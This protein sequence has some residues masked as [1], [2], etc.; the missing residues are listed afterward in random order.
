[1][2]KMIDITGQTFGKLTIS[3]YMG[4]DGKSSTWL[5]IC[6]CGRNIKVSR[7]KLRKG[8]KSCGCLTAR[9]KY[10][11]LFEKVIAQNKPNR[12]RFVYVASYQGILFKIGCTSNVSERMLSLSA[13]FP[14]PIELVCFVELN[15]ASIL[16]N[17]LHIKYGKHQY[18]IMKRNGNHFSR[19]FFRID[20]QLI[21]KD[22]EELGL[23]VIHD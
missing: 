11:N 9:P 13:E 15:G 20:L 7:H 8:K 3:C 4:S 6:K 22:L 19:E 17:A 1:M 21:I 18:P 14:E 10:Q 16:E 23:N 12:K 5:A 2:S